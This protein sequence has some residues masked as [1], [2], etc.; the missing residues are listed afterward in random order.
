MTKDFIRLGSTKI[1]EKDETKV[2]RMDIAAKNLFKRQHSLFTRLCNGFPYAKI[3][4]GTIIYA[5]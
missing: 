1:D 2:R 4:D 3:D 5:M